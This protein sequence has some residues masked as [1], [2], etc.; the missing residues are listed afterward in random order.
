MGPTNTQKYN[1]LLLR[2]LANLDEIFRIKI[3]KTYL[4]IKRNFAESRFDASGILIGKYCE[5][6]IRLL[7]DKIFGSFTPFGSRISNF[8][9]ETRRMIASPVSSATESERILIPRTLMTLYTMRNKRGIGHV[10][11]DI[12]ANKIDAITMVT[13]CDWIIC[14]LIRIYHNLSLEE[15]Q[16]IVDSISE[17]Q[18]PF[19]WEVA[20]KKRVLKE[21]VPAKDQVLMLLYSEKDSAVLI[22][23][24]FSW[25]EYSNLSVFKSRVIKDLHKS[26]LLEYDKEIEAI[27]LSPKGAKHVEE[28]IL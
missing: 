25:V 16:D 11:G 9:D 21:G 27:Y 5:I 1:N 3:S 15:A 6:I 24:I 26:R 17:R 23:D 28:N 12:E 22:E 13:L 7:Q 4:D 19:I 2:S 20:G 14:E 10:G 8:A 18:L